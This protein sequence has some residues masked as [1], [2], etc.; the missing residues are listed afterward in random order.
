MSPRT[1]VSPG[2]SSYSAS[3]DLFSCWATKGCA[4]TLG[5]NDYVIQEPWLKKIQGLC[6]KYSL[7]PL[8]CEEMLTA[9]C[10]TWHWTWSHSVPSPGTEHSVCQLPT[11]LCRRNIPS[12]PCVTPAWDPQGRE[13][14]EKGEA[15]VKVWVC[16]SWE[17]SP[18]RRRQQ[19]LSSVFTLL[20]LVIW[21]LP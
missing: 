2:L 21:W 7:K 20:S 5:N 17:G 4:K 13:G 3:S 9:A 19:R 8:S 6:S 1:S 18:A 11:L 14:G 15:K 12:R 16:K 10:F